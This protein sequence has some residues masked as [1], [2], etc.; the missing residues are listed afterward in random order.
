MNNCT[1]IGRLTKDPEIRYT[2]ESMAVCT[3]AIAVNRF[4]DV[5]DFFPVKTWGKTAENCA[6]FLAKGRLVAVNGSMQND[7]WE[8]DGEKHTFNYLN[9]QRVEFLERAKKE[10]APTQDAEQARQNINN[11]LGI[12]AKWDDVPDDIPF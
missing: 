10:E 9:A 3:F 1:F 2:K 12:N 8:K 5:A 7:S 11:V 6:K 4:N